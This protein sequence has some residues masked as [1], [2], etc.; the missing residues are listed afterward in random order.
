MSYGK[1]AKNVFPFLS[2]G[3]NDLAGIVMRR[4]PAHQ[5]ATLHPIDQSHCALVLQE[6]LG[7]ERSD[8]ARLPLRHRLNRQECLML[9]GFNCFSQRGTFTKVQEA[10]N[11]VAELGEF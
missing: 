5:P 6:E 4:S 8:G 7:R 10:A 1:T 3:H 2:E 11:M 9:P